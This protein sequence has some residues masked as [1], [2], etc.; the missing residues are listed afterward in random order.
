[1]AIH[2]AIKF[3]FR[4]VTSAN[5]ETSRASMSLSLFTRWSFS[6]LFKGFLV[7]NRKYEETKFRLR[8]VWSLRAI[9][10]VLWFYD[11]WIQKEMTSGIWMERSYMWCLTI[12]CWSISHG[13]FCEMMLWLKCAI[14][15]FVIMRKYTNWG[16]LFVYFIARINWLGN[17][18]HY[19]SFLIEIRFEKS[20]GNCS[21]EIYWK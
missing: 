6:L 17:R 20:N 16:V 11:M 10:L 21:R 13:W 14:G 18:R 9:F 4:V 2:Y 12:R 8:N 19:G 7:Y 1:M 3:K 5:F 15:R